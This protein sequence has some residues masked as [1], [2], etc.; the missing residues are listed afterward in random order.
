MQFPIQIYYSVTQPWICKAECQR[1]FLL[2]WQVI[3]FNQMIYL[4][5]LQI[6]SCQLDTL[7]IQI[8]MFQVTNLYFDLHLQIN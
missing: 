2:I 5:I 7:V 4:Y 3:Y 8:I 1:F 6:I